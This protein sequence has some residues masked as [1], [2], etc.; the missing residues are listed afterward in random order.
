MPKAIPGTGG[1]RKWTGAAMGS[2]GFVP[3]NQPARRSA[4]CEG[5]GHAHALGCRTFTAALIEH[6]TDEE[7]NERYRR[8]LKRPTNNMFDE[9]QLYVAAPGGHRAKRRRTVAHQ[10]QISY[11]ED[12]EGSAVVDV[13]IVRPP[14]LVLR[15]NTESTAKVVGS[16]TDPCGICT[17]VMPPACFI[18][19]GCSFDSHS[20][21]RKLSKAIAHDVDEK[22]KFH[23]ATADPPTAGPADVDKL[24]D[25]LEA[26]LGPRGLAA[27][28]PPTMEEVLASIGITWAPSRPETSITA[29]GDVGSTDLEPTPAAPGDVL[30][31]APYPSPNEPFHVHV[32]SFCSPHKTGTAVESITKFLGRAFA[33]RVASPTGM[34]RT[35]S[36]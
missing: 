5:G 19:R 3:G 16:Q 33:W 17:D 35:N 24:P 34:S 18:G 13:D 8:G 1:W 25:A 36:T 2:T 7:N 26:L 27:L 10:C 4:K 20:V 22:N 9:S 15:Y 29:L 30:Q 23:Y 12:E 14:Q 6:R 32:A 11:Q 21:N 28:P 31:P